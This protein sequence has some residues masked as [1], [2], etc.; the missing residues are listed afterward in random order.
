MINV[1]YNNKLF[2]TCQEKKVNIF[3]DDTYAS[4][5]Y[6]I[7]KDTQSK[8][9]YEL[10]LEIESYVVMLLASKIDKPDFLPAKTFAECYY[11]LREHN[12]YDA[13]TLGDTCLFVRG[14]FPN[15]GKRYGIRKSYYTKIGRTSY[16]TVS[17]VLHPELFRQLAKHFD[18][19]GDF[20]QMSVKNDYFF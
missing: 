1:F 16:E 14:V 5:F 19:L 7:V 4:A 20:I 2:K 17:E 15:Y 12:K 10:P 3:M 8:T 9:G 6:D 18:F 11:T 13:K